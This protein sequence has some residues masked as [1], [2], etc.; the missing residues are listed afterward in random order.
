MRTIS[1][2]WMLEMELDL[3]ELVWGAAAG[4]VAPYAVVALWEWMH[5][6]AGRLR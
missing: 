2:L 1:T 6:G 4:S 3:A 5:S